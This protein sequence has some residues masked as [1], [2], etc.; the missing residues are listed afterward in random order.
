MIS[1][2]GFLF[3]SYTPNTE[4]EKSETWK[5]KH[6]QSKNK[7]KQNTKGAEEQDRKLLGNNLSIPAKH[8]SKGPS[9]N[10]ANKGQVGSSDFCP[11]QTIIMYPNPI[12]GIRRWRLSS[13]WALTSPQRTPV[14]SVE[15]LWGTWA[16]TLVQHYRGCLPF[17]STWCKRRSTADTEVLPPSINKA[18]CPTPH[19]SG[20]WK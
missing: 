2:L 3:A 7:D 9:S 13:P 15:T 6:E 18:S 14:I 16:S 17:P 11:H 1:F 12:T 20:G 5:W 4:L 8:H 10:L 19:F